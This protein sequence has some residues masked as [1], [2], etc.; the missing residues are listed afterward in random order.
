MGRYK[1]NTGEIIEGGAIEVYCYK[2]ERVRLQYWRRAARVL[3]LAFST[4]AKYV[5][6]ISYVNLKGTWV[7][8]VTFDFS[9]EKMDQSQYL[10]KHEIK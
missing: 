3:S 8:T 6:Y 10:K 2:T 1:L 7:C 9:N 4:G 5:Y